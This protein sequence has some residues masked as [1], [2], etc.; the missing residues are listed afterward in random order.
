LF[1]TVAMLSIHQSHIN[2]RNRKLADNSQSE[3]PVGFSPYGILLSF[4]IISPK[5]QSLE[6]IYTHTQDFKSGT[7]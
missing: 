1:L 7:G 6:G 3:L 4:L 2:C 5:C